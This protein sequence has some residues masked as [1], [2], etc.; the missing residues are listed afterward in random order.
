MGRRPKRAISTKYPVTRYRET[1]ETNKIYKQEK[2]YTFCQTFFNSFRFTSDQVA[3]LLQTAFCF[4]FF[5][6][7]SI[8]SIYIHY[9][10]S[11]HFFSNVAFFFRQ[12]KRKIEASQSGVVELKAELFKKSHAAASANTALP[13]AITS[14]KKFKSIKTINPVKP[15]RRYLNTLNLKLLMRMSHYRRSWPW[16]G[17]LCKGK[18]KSMI[19]WRK[20]NKVFNKVLNAD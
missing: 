7:R 15:R 12:M 11:T 4:E 2:S 20:N 19:N 1:V 10:D 5:L 14:G 18:Q 6:F 13:T 3:A 17:L 9:H 8:L 16:V